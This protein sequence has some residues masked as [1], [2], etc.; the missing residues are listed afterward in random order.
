MKLIKRLLITVLSMITISSCSSEK[1]ITFGGYKFNSTLTSST[2]ALVSKG[3]LSFSFSTRSLND[4][5]TTEQVLLGGSLTKCTVEE[6]NVVSTTKVKVSISGLPNMS[7]EN[8]LGYIG[9]LPSSFSDNGLGELIELTIVDSL[10]YVAALS[11]KEITT[12]YEYSIGIGL[13]NGA[14]FNDDNISNDDF[15]FS[16]IDE[17]KQPSSNL[18]FESFHLADNV[19]YI[20]FTSPLLDLSS[21]SVNLTSNTNDFQYS[22]SLAFTD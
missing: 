5:I 13:L 18:V 8:T 9:I 1:S 14:V 20:T 3:K 15:S 2:Y 4:S 17:E 11:S 12:R 6:A 22:G 21:Y 16:S 10:F 19:C 7:L